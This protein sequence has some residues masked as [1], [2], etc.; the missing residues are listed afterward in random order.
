MDGEGYGAVVPSFQQILPEHLL[1]ARVGVK[2]GVGEDGCRD[3]I[4]CG[5]YHPGIHR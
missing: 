5:L 2:G 1:W 3:E 4:D